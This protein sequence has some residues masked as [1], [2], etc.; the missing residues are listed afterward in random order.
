MAVITGAGRGIGLS[1]ARCFAAGGYRVALLARSADQLKA[2][3][4]ELGFA[5]HEAWPIVCDVTDPSSV[6]RAAA[7]ILQE[8][9]PAVHVL[10]NN[11]G[12]AVPAGIGKV[13]VADYFLQ[14]RVNID[15]V[16]LMTRALWPALLAGAAQ[17]GGAGGLGACIVNISS[18][19]AKDPFAGLELYGGMKACVNQWTLG[20]SREGKRAGIRA[21]AIAP[22]AVDTELLERIFPQ[23]PRTARLSPESLA[24]LG[25][26]MAEGTSSHVSGETVYVS[27]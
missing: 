27:K 9:G 23:V 13:S 26:S 2:A 6:E 21:Y 18:M 20:W 24:E 1:F 7:S 15:G 12:V 10:V 3:A 22:G 16:F 25:F 17:R 5:G 8:C 19:A 14:A 4:D 11:A